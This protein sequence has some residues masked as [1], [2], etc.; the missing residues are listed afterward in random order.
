MPQHSIGRDRAARGIPFFVST[1][2]TLTGDN[3]GISD[4][5]SKPG[6]SVGRE[7]MAPV[8]EDAPGGLDAKTGEVPDQSTSS[9]SKDRL[10]SM[11]G[12]SSHPGPA[13]A[14]LL[15]P[16]TEIDLPLA[17]TAA[18]TA[19]ARTQSPAGDHFFVVDA[20]R[21]QDPAVPPP[22]VTGESELRVDTGS[23][24]AVLPTA[25]SKGIGQ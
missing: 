17:D 23:A 13:S 20:E 3:T 9:P 21:A 16:V 14:A 22:A 6:S 8:V 19:S 25:Q 18:A 24:Q 4:W 2:L 15:M 12:P 11:P 10:D 5:E 7:F 1:D